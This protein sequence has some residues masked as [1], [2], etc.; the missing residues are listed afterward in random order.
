MALTHEE[1]LAIN[2][3][4]GTGRS[5]PQPTIRNPEFQ[6]PPTFLENFDF[7]EREGFIRDFGANA[8][9]SG[10]GST[11]A[12]QRAI[13]MKRLDIARKRLEFQKA[14]GLRDIG[15]AREKGLKAAINNALQRGIFRS[16]I[17][18]ENVNEVKREAT[19]AKSDLTTDIQ[20]ALDDLKLRRESANVVSGVGGSAGGGGNISL[21]EAD[22]LARDTARDEL[23]RAQRNQS[24]VSSVE[25]RERGAGGV[26]PLTPPPITVGRPS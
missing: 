11:A 19:E 23:V 17:R 26:V 7:L 10:S 1:F 2:D 15:Q 22:L 20:F 9:T 4:F 6:T 13:T 24:L 25:I 16:G 8:V 3:P 5:G 12:A 21:S 18:I 14:T